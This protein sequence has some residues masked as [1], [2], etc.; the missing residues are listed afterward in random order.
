MFLSG[1]SLLRNDRFR[2]KT[3]RNDALKGQSRQ[4]L[5]IPMVSK[6]K[7]GSTPPYSP[8]KSVSLFYPALRPAYK[9]R[10]KRK[11]RF[12]CLSEGR[13]AAFCGAYKNLFIVSNR[14]TCLR[15]VGRVVRREDKY[16]FYAALAAVFLF[17]FSAARKSKKEYFL[18][19]SFRQKK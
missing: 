12:I 15:R 4:A 13:L 19:T 2:T 17:T 9:K 3:I 8:Q 5:F 18:L 6:K 14:R 7:N 10:L 1:I 11:R 16:S